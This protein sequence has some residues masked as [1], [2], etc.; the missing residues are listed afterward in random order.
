M[1]LTKI[2]NV[3]LKAKDIKIGDVIPVYESKFLK[4]D[5]IPEELEKAFEKFRSNATQYLNDPSIVN[6][7]KQHKITMSPTLFV[8]LYSFMKG[9]EKLFPDLGCKDYS[10]V[11][12]YIENPTANF[13]EVFE[14]HLFR[15][16]EFAIMA[17]LYLQSI[18]IDSEYVYGQS[19]RYI[20]DDFG[21]LL[22]FIIIHELD[23]DFV[24]DPTNNNISTIELTP[25][26]KVS[27]QA[28]L[29]K[30]ERKVA[31]FETRDIITNRTKFYGYG[32]GAKV[33]KDM[34][35]EKEQPAPKVPV[36]DFS[37]S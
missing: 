34:V 2:N 33:L 15:D 8:Q 37:R 20:N 5:K 4:I 1:K 26:Q 21:Y 36:K 27:V 6:F 3:S 18:D 31:F 30:G 13:S 12:F 29:L 7:M 22:S 35:F 10:S 16:V 25:Q 28:K 14:K 23:K 17:Q 19:L 24:F 11:Y 9:V 32:D